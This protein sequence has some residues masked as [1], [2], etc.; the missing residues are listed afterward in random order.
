MS[1]RTPQRL[2]KAM[3]WVAILSESEAHSALRA[4]RRGDG[5]W[6]GSEAVVHYGGADAVIAQAIALRHRLR[7]MGKLQLETAC[8]PEPAVVQSGS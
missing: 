7:A 3:Q 8:A 6:G 4:H 2:V 1:Q 5:R